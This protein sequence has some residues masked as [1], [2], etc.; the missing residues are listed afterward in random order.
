MEQK[1]I[2]LTT[3]NPAQLPI[4][5]LEKMAQAFVKS[6]LF[7]VQ[8][9]DQAVA[10]MLIAQAEG[11]HPAIA[12]RDFHIIKGRHS[13]KA[14]AMLSRFH[15]NQ[16]KVQW[17]EYSDT[18][19]SGTFSHPSG[20]TATITW[21]IDQAK[22]AGLAGKMA[23][24]EAPAAAGML[25]RS[26]SVGDNLSKDMGPVEFAA[27]KRSMLQNQRGEG[28]ITPPAAPFAERNKRM[29]M[30]N[31]RGEGVIT[32]PAPVRP[33]RGGG[34]D[35]EARRPTQDELDQMQMGSD[36]MRKGGRV[37]AY[38]SG[39]SV[40]SASKRADGIAM[41]GKTRGKYIQW[42]KSAKSC[43]SSRKAN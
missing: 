35:P 29:L 13:L 16:G 4:E 12:A 41:R 37:K 1:S 18:V 34:R 14:D 31:Q 33:T 27:G 38:K 20:G 25:G 2:T 17:N 5:Q 32:P 6:G 9:V 42:I 36:Y 23:A 43:V 19:V 7:G 21:T 26:K 22:A 10:L 11:L 8:T 39:G 15:A 28:V 24:R 40:S 3:Q 30:Q